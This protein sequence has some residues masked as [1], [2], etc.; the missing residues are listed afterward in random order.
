MEQIIKFPN[1]YKLEVG[2]IMYN[3]DTKE[4]FEVTACTRIGI[5][6]EY[7]WGVTAKLLDDNETDT[8]KIDQMV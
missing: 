2:T 7:N 5:F 4:R 6:E 1:K 8:T 3:E